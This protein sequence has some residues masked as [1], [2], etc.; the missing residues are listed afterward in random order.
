MPSLTFCPRVHGIIT[1]LVDN[2]CVGSGQEADDVKRD[3]LPCAPHPLTSAMVY[4][5][6]NTSAG[7]QGRGLEAALLTFTSGG[8]GASADPSCSAGISKE[9]ANHVQPP[10]IALL[11]QKHIACIYPCNAILVLAPSSERRG[12]HS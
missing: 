4:S 6:T 9:G 2:F 1:V 3:S 5:I 11:R 8:T 12:K 10:K 7:L